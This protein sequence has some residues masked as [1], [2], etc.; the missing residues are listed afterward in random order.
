M[1]TF[2]SDARRT[3]KG[4]FDEK[5]PAVD[6]CTEKGDV[7]AEEKHI[8]SPA[9]IACFKWPIYTAPLK[10]PFAE[11]REAA[12]RQFYIDWV[13]TFVNKQDNFLKRL[14]APLEIWYVRFPPG[15]KRG[16]SSRAGNA[17]K[18]NHWPC[19]SAQLERS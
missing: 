5:I 14:M 18:A 1:S 2:A 10:D 11:P 17:P 13:D 9:L 4:I 8:V 12:H 16:R 19:R 15:K 7:N 6:G 3:L